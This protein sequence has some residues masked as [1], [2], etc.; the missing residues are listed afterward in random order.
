MRAHPLL[1]W[2][3]GLHTRARHVRAKGLFG[4]LNRPAGA[5]SELSGLLHPLREAMDE[6]FSCDTT[7]GDCRLEAPSAG[8]CFVASMVVQDLFGGCIVFGEVDDTSHYWNK[9]GGLEVDVTGDQFRQPEVQ[10]K[11]GQI[12]PSKTLFRREPQERLSLGTNREVMKLYDRFCGRLVKRLKDRG[13][14]DLA[15]KLEEK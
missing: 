2:Q 4:S 8:H 15:A 5:E 11:K 7:W 9:I 6:T 12:R 1:D 13:Y 14:A 3:I 10:V